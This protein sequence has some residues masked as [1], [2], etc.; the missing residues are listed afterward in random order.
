MK[1]LFIRFV[2][3]PDQKQTE[4]ESRSGNPAREPLPNEPV[5]RPLDV[6]RLAFVKHLVETGQI[7][8]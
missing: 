7:H 4:D 2:L 6:N 8:D 1:L 3:V 5:S